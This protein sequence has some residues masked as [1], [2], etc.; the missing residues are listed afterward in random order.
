[1]SACNGSATPEE[2][3]TGAINAMKSCI[4]FDTLTLGTRY[5]YNDIIP[6]PEGEVLVSEFRWSDD[7]PRHD[8]YA[9]LRD[10]MPLTDA[11]LSVFTNNMT[12]A[13]DASS[14]DCVKFDYCDKGGNINLVIDSVVLNVQDL[15]ELDG[16]TQGDI[17]ISVTSDQNNCGVVT[18]SGKF[19]PFNFQEQQQMISFAVGGQELFVDNICPCQ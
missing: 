5:V 17:K 1:M 12:L 18:L 2:T 13:V 3:R 8:G 11:K 4:I 15:R 10:D 6:D 19:N 14:L 16:K 7:T 9:E